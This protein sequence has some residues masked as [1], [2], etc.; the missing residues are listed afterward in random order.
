[1]TLPLI[2]VIIP[3][4]NSARFVT[5]AVESALSQT[6][7]PIEVIVVDDG[8]T[9]ETPAIVAPFENRIR[10]IRQENRGLAGARNRGIQEARGEFIAFLDADDRWMPEKLGQQWKCFS[11]DPTVALVHTDALYWNEDAGEIM[12]QQGGR[13][14]YVGDCSTRLFVANRILASSVV[15]R[16]DCLER[17]G[18]FCENAPGVEDLDLWL[19]IVRFY[20]F[21]Y[22]DQ[23]L[24]LY[25]KHNWNMSKNDL[26]MR[27]GELTA[28]ENA[29]SADPALV[30]KVGK[31]AVRHK[32][33]DL[34]LAV[35]YYYFDQGEYRLARE[36]I[37][38]A[39]SFRPIQPYPL[40]LWSSTW[41]PSATIRTLRR[42]KQKIS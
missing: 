11:D 34:C 22:V 15:V 6:Y 26:Q 8:S 33:Y 23:P 20:P 29:L 31:T 30:S 37:S 4:Y 36:Y 32:L 17:V 41:L 2:S 5:E 24:V 9:D 13:A 25:R 39:I 1:M 19:R 3:S 28:I 42:I 35:G 7:R 14:D 16:R 40:V 27:K 38:R 12:P 10:Y 18:L 21:G